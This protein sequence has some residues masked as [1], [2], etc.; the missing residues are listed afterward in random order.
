MVHL[1]YTPPVVYISAYVHH[2]RSFA[3][4]T[5][6]GPENSW[7]MSIW[8]GAIMEAIVEPKRSS[9]PRVMA[10][11]KCCAICRPVVY[12]ATYPYTPEYTPPVVYASAYIHHRRSFVAYTSGDPE[13]SSSISAWAGAIM[14]TVAEPKRSSLPRVVGPSNV[15]CDM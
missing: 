6:G 12:I 14:R 13:N 7:S 2:R 3:A 8:A 11:L 1:L 10:P 5:S 15:L 4:Q 9:I